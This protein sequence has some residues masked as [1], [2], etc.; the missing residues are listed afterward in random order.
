MPWFT[1]PPNPNEIRRQATISLLRSLEARLSGDFSACVL[2]I[3]NGQSPESAFSEFGSALANLLRQQQSRIADLQNSLRFSEIRIEGLL[4]ENERLRNEPV[5]QKLGQAQQKVLDLSLRA[6]KAEYSLAATRRAL[7]A[8]QSARQCETREMQ[9][10]FVT[11]NS[12]IAKQRIQLD[13]LG[14]NMLPGEPSDA[15]TPEVQS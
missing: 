7:E 5:R 12:I 6:E 14:C 8:E 4:H 13:N 3:E 1:P 11:Q 9:R 15:E 2:A 10:A